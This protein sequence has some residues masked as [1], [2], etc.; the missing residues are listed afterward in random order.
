MLARFDHETGQLVMRPG[1]LQ[2]QRRSAIA[3]EVVHVERGPVPDDDRLAA[4][5][6]AAVSSEAARRL[7]SVHALGEALAWAR[8][9]H[10]LAEELHVDIQTVR[11]R[12]SRLH[13]SER[14]YL[15]RRLEQ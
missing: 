11:V 6:E 4:R 15:R 2:R 5:E 7:I 9:E 1:M 10:E 3:H 8:S 13:P 14:H 12:L